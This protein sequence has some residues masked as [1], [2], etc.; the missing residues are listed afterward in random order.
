MLQ[1]LSKDIKIS[2]KFKVLLLG[3]VLYEIGEGY[4]SLINVAQVVL[5]FK[6]DS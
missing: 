1:M 2:S 6:A 3:I 5:I 4:R